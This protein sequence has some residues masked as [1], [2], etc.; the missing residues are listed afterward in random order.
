[1]NTRYARI[2]EIRGREAKVRISFA[3]FI[4]AT[5]WALAPSK[6]PLIWLGVVLAGQAA[7]WLI[8][9]TIRGF[10]GQTP[11]LAW[12]V[13]ACVSLFANSLIYSAIAAYLW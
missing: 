7:D 3:G 1:M 2:A 11:S 10:G 12:R 4:A 8:F 13:T 6:W 5:V 9:R